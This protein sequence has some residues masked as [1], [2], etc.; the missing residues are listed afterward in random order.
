MSERTCCRGG[1]L[2]HCCGGTLMRLQLQ[3]RACLRARVRDLPLHRHW[4]RLRPGLLFQYL[5]VVVFLL[6][7]R[8]PQSSPAIKATERERELG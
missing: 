7:F 6:F 2:S 1:G 8:A 4:S 3:V 5:Y